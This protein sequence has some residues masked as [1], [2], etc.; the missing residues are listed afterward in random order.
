MRAVEL[1]EQKKKN[2][3]ANVPSKGVLTES[4]VRMKRERS[5]ASRA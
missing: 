5:R 4:L 2:S 1:V 3:T